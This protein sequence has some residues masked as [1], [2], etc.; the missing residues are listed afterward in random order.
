MKK[1]FIDADVIIDFLTMREP[2]GEDAKKL[3][4]V[5][6]DGSIELYSSAL[7]IA[8]ANYII[9]KIS[10]P[11]VALAKIKKLLPLVRIC[12]MD[13]KA[14]DLAVASAFTD[15]EDALQN[16]CAEGGD[17]DI[18]TTRN[19]KDYKRSAVAV[20]TP[21]ELIAGLFI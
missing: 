1:V 16:F 20:L 13:Q 3:F 14:V 21:K 9:G 19:I 8:N 2:F 11:K 15:F 4:Q 6:L 17:I 12:A 7:A 5:S 10:S 18:I